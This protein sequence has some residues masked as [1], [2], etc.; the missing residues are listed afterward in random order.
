MLVQIKHI[1]S[2]QSTVFGPS[3]PLPHQVW[4]EP[5]QMIKHAPVYQ[6]H[7]T[8]KLILTHRPKAMRSLH[9][10]LVWCC[11][12][13]T[14]CITDNITCV[15]ICMIEHIQFPAPWL[16][17]LLSAHHG[18]EETSEIY[19]SNAAQVIHLVVAMFICLSIMRINTTS[20]SA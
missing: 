12:K 9:S 20:T 3:C 19:H 1:R 11:L 16:K 4:T 8:F 5:S 10:S 2:L 17:C 18:E 13:S 6:F 7:G 15:S 14:P